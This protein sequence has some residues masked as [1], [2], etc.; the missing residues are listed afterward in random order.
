ML[1]LHFDSVTA[2]E[3]ETGSPDAAHPLRS[4]FR[5]ML[6]PFVVSPLAVAADLVESLTAHGWA[7]RWVVAAAFVAVAAARARDRP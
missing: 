7:E 3:A 6:L 2:L 4:G 1:G 5:A